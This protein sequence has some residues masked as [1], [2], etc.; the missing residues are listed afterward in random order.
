MSSCVLVRYRV[1]QKIRHLSGFFCW[2]IVGTRTKI[3]FMLGWVKHVV[4]KKFIL[5]KIEISTVIVP[6]FY[7]TVSVEPVQITVLF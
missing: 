5:S 4:F 1:L 3:F 2:E 6:V 7:F